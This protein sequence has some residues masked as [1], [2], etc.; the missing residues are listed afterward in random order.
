MFSPPDILILFAVKEE[1]APFQKL[2]RG[3]SAVRAVTG[4]MGQRNAESSVRRELAAARPA[5]VI[6][7]GFAGGLDPAL[8]S[9]QVIFDA[10]EN[11][12]L[13]GAL[14]RAGATAALFHCADRVAVTSRAKAALQAETGAQAVEMESGVIRQICRE[15]GVPSA[16]VRVISDIAQEDLPLD[17]NAMYTADYRLNFGKLA[18]TLLRSPA[19]IPRLLAFS[20][21]VNFAARELATVLH[22]ITI[23]A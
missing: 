6:T 20:K 5:L 9:G 2:A 23:R 1:M 14:T 17:F 3:N 19:L 22:S 13:V 15:Q 11:F 12:P 8:Q 21:Q 10:D 18:W 16:T 7:S 4:G